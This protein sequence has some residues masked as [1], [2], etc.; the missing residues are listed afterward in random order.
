VLAGERQERLGSLDEVIREKAATAATVPGISVVE[1]ALA[2]AA[3]GATSLH[4]PTERGLATAL[5]EIS[6]A[7][8]VAL[9]IDPEVV[10]WFEPG[11]AVCKVLGADPWGTLASGTLLAAFAAADAPSVLATLLKAG[12]EAAVIGE[13][14]L[15]AGVTTAAGGQLLLFEQDEVA[16]VLGVQL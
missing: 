4:D 13:A 7:S 10:L 11:L 9:V 15:G 14:G 2:A 1:P 8:G 6:E 12:F 3:L 16:R 5:W